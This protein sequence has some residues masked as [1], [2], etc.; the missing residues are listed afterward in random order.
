MKNVERL[1][2]REFL[3]EGAVNLFKATRTP[4]TTLADAKSA[5]A[6]A[7]AKFELAAQDAEDE[8]LKKQAAIDALSATIASHHSRQGDLEAVIGEA[9]NA[10]DSIGQINH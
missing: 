3:Q 5:L 4:E 8:R 1:G 10:S 6:N 2:L 9:M 7:A